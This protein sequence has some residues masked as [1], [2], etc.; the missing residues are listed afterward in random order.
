MIESIQ[1]ILDSEIDLNK[2]KS[3]IKKTIKINAVNKHE[4]ETLKII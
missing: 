4:W 3:E 2:L 1:G